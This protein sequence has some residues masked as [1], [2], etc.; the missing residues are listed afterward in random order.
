[1]HHSIRK[2]NGGGVSASIYGRGMNRKD[3]YYVPIVVRTNSN[4]KTKW[5]SMSLCGEINIMSEQPGSEVMELAC[6]RAIM[7]YSSLALD[8]ENL[9]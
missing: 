5:W 8:E 2:N 3:Y 1:M 6:V 7:P 4:V 9:S